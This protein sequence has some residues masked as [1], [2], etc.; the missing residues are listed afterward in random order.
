[1]SLRSGPWKLYLALDEVMGARDG[2]TARDCEELYDVRSDLGE[3]REV[4]AENPDVVKRLLGLE[5]SARADLGDLDRE[6]ADQRPAG[7][8]EDPVAQLLGK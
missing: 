6:G 7:W 8:I 2:K 1:M 5:E 3:T 4:A